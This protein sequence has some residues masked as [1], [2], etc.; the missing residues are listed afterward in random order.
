MARPEA[1]GATSE[2]LLEK[3]E[4]G[5]PLLANFGEYLVVDQ[6]NVEFNGLDD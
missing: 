2:E 4:V 3:C 6:R 5:E 1:I